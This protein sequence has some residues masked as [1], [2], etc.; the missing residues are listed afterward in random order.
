[1]TYM[2]VQYPARGPNVKAR[3]C[4]TLRSCTAGNPHRRTAAP[5]AWSFAEG[6]LRAGLGL[7]DEDEGA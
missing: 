2:T 4:T 1:M 7:G 6:F 3:L 5:V